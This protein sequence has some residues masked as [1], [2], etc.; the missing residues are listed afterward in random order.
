MNEMSEN[1][2]SISHNGMFIKFHSSYCLS[3]NFYEHAIF[4]SFGLRKQFYSTY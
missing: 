3:E 4:N 2:C 1:L